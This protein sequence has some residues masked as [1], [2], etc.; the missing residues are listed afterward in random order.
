[1]FTKATLK[2]YYY[3]A[4]FI[5]EQNYS[6]LKK[7]LMMNEVIALAIEIVRKEYFP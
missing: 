7:T 1:M 3:E 6:D 2:I 5:L 4:L